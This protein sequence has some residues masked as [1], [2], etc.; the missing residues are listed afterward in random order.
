M[1]TM[2]STQTLDGRIYEVDTRLRP[3]GQAGLLVSSLHAFELYQQKS[4]WLWEHQALARSRSVA[5][6]QTVRDVFEQIRL[7]ILTLPRDPQVVRE[8]V[9]AMRQKMQDHLGSS[10]TQQENG[11][12]I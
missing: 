4:A 11:F 9:R 2:L 3:S 10:K 1:M 6:D 12:F 8:E 5:G 7:A